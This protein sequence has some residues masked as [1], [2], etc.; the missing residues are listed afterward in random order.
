MTKKQILRQLC[1]LIGFSVA[2]QSVGCHSNQD[3]SSLLPLDVKP[4]PIRYPTLTLTIKN[5]TPRPRYAFKNIFVSNYSVVLVNGQNYLSSAWDG[6]TDD[7]KSGL[8][9]SYNFS[10]TNAYSPG[11]S[12]SNLLLY[13]SGIPV[14]ENDLFCASSNSVSGFCTPSINNPNPAANNCANDA[15]SIPSSSTLGT[16]F[17]GMSDCE[18]RYIGLNINQFDSNSSGVPD[19]LKLKCGLN[20]FN[21]IDSSVDLSNDGLSNIDKCKAHIP[22]DEYALTPEN[23]LYAY[24]YNTLSSADGTYQFTIDNISL[25]NQGDHNFIA[26]YIVESREAD[27]TEA[28]SS[29]YIILT[30]STLNPRVASLDYW[31]PST[32]VQVTIPNL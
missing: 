32:N 16:T 13:L 30:T 26:I 28:L 1:L 4:T 22:Y 11:S 20:P 5:Y 6:I 25:L 18:K 24:H 17:V 9:L 27:S 10:L 21:A 31:G 3:E 23:E 7:F 12:F 15:F 2:Y 8:G 29:A 19:Y 14:G